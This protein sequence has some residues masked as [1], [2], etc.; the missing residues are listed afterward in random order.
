MVRHLIIAVRHVYSVD[1]LWLRRTYW[2]SVIKSLFDLS[3]TRFGLGAKVLFV[4]PRVVLVFIQNK[5]FS[6]TQ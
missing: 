1:I 3:A 2:G 5:L 4:Y 6:K